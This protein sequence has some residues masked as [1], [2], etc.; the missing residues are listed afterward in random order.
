MTRKLSISV[1]DDVAA[2]LDRQGNV[3][4]A[5]TEVIRAHLT[6]QRTIDVLRLAGFDPSEEGKRRWR[7]RLAQPIP[8]H[9]V[10]AG[11]QMI[12][13]RSDPAGA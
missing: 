10:E 7:E 4:S 3:S 6:S 12:G 1:P 13:R 11:R 5:I 2:W 9:A 8:P